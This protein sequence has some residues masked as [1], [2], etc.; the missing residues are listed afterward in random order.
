MNALTK[1]EFEELSQEQYASCASFYLPTHRKG[2]EMV[3]EQDQL[4]FKNQLKSVRKRLMDLGW[5]KANID[6]FTLPALELLKNPPFWRNQTEGLA[7]FLTNDFLKYYNLPFK[8]EP[9]FH[10][11]RGFYLRPLIPLFSGSGEFYV[12]GLNLHKITLYEG[13]R[14]LLKKVNIKDLTP[15]RLEEVVGYDYKERFLQFRSQQEGHGQASFHGHGEW[16]GE[17]KKD[18]ILKF[19]RSVNNEIVQLIGGKK[20][21]LLVIGQEY[22]FPIYKKVNT[23]PYLMEEYLDVNPEQEDISAL[24]RKVWN[25]IYVRFDRERVKKEELIRQ[26]HNTPRT[27][28]D[29]VEIIPEAVNGRV[30]TLFVQKGSEIWGV[31]NKNDNLVIIEEKPSDSNVSLLNLA[32]IEVIRNGG[33]VY[34]QIAEAMPMPYVALN[35]LYRF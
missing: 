9:D 21:P 11:A 3:N 35:A 19:F 27:S 18:E 30:D 17:F 26:L 23:Y 5:E 34:E 15:Q 20:H 16:K 24:H 25:K 33:K 6:Q 31:F 22:L 4:V 29:L 28:F 8:V 32:I 7:I 12:L 10:I 13:N 1:K 14:E 2:M